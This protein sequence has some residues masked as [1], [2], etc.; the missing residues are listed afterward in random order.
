MDIIYYI[1]QDYNL[2]SLQIES[3]LE[4]DGKKEITFKR[5][6][7]DEGGNFAT[8]YSSEYLPWSG[9]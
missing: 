1:L 8:E 6:N 2:E 9:L 4:V 5:L 7:T 3:I